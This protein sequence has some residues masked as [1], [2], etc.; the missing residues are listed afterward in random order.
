MECILNKEIVLSDEQKK[1]VEDA[2]KKFYEG[3]P[4]Y[5][6]A[7]PAGSGKTTLIPYIIDNM[8]LLD[9][10]VAYVAY[11]GKAARVLRDNG[12]PATTIHHLIYDAF[13][14]RSGKWHFRKKSFYDLEQ[15]KLIVIDEISMMSTKLLSDL[16][17]YS[18]PLLC[19]G[20]DAQL[21]PIMEDANTLLKHPDFVLTKIYRQKE[22]SGILDLATQI[23][24]TG[25]IHSD[26]MDDSVK[27]INTDEGEKISLSMLNWADVILCATNKTR[28]EFTDLIRRSKGIEEKYPLLYEPIIITKNYWDILSLN[29]EPLTNGTICKITNIDYYLDNPFD[30]YA[31]VKMTPTYDE[32][33]SFVC[34]ISLNG[35]F[36]L[37]EVGAGRRYNSQAAER[38][39]CDFAYVLTIHKSQGSQF[40]KVLVYTKDA[41]GDKKK[42]LYTAVTRAK[43]KLVYVQ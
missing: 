11:T 25:N 13:K 22:N 17:S 3:K 15:Y 29:G 19:L 5:T 37:A 30:K 14:D 41:F 20:D 42:M 8:G 34:K 36:G 21:P 23:R 38:V 9:Y 27:T 28:Y 35:F 6:I 33:D 43:N 10:E 1:C 40:D 26:I 18:I 12:L 16:L 24:T 7:A 31:F 39:Q 32:N 4:E 2:A